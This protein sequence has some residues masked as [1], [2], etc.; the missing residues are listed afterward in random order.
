M[1]ANE[2]T[3]VDNLKEEERA[4]LVLLKHGLPDIIKKVVRNK[5]DY[6]GIRLK[7]RV[8]RFVGFKGTQGDLMMIQGVL[9]VKI[10]NFYREQGLQPEH[11]SIQCVKEEDDEIEFSVPVL[12]DLEEDEPEEVDLT[13]IGQQWETDRDGVRD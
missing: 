7:D 5:A 13:E 11:W 8:L 12:D 6:I 9:A 3:G 1:R 4:K 2:G 10:S